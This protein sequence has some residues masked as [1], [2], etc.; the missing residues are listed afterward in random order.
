MGRSTLSRVA[1]QV[2]ED[3]IDRSGQLFQRSGVRN[4]EI[5]GCQPL[6]SRRLSR[7]ST[8]SVIGVHAPGQHTRQ[9]HLVGRVDHDPR[10]TEGIAQN[11]CLDD[12]DPLETLQVTSNAA[13]DRRVGERL[14]LAELFRI[15]EDNGR[16]LLPVDH[17]I[18]EHLGP[19]VDY[20]GK[21]LPPWFQDPMTDPIG[22]DHP[23]PGSRQHP[24]HFALPGSD[25]TG[26]HP[27]TFLCDHRDRR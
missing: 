3:E 15:G 9:P 6:S 21:C 23:D 22:V 5:A 26:Q 25:A 18:S 12:R 2:R 17:A 13:E 1:L 10:P 20:P 19:A 27:A 11:R 4:H 16:Q 14:Q 8:T 24:A 7:Q